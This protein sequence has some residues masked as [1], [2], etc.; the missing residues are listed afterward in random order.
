MSTEPKDGEPAAVDG[1]EPIDGERFAE[2]A[3]LE[4]SEYD[5]FDLDI[6]IDV[7]D[8]D[9]GNPLGGFDL[10]NL[11]AQAQ[12]M[13]QQLVEAQAKVV[14]QV[15]EGQAGGGVVR[16]RVTGGLEFE[17]VTIDPSAV[18]PS[19]VEMLQDLVLAALRDAMAKVS[20]LNA[21][22]MQGFGAG[23]ALGGLL[24]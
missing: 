2:L 5:E 20:D 22:A 3:E 16:V 13:Q 6:E 15:V 23:G 1:A 4:A 19:D 14:E 17:S 24:P 8:D 11:L 18:D 10:G 9:D 12:N 7:E 21:Q